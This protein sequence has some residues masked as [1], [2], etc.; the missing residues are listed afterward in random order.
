MG[1]VV[2]AGLAL[3]FCVRWSAEDARRAGFDCA[4][5]TDACR[6]IDLDGSVAAAL[7]SLEAAGVELL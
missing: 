2:C 1:R 4:V 5:V 7:A 6:G 3:D